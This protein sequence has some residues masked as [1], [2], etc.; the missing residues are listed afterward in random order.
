MRSTITFEIEELGRKKTCL[1]FVV[2]FP[3]FP[4]RSALNRISNNTFQ[5]KMERHMLGSVG[6]QPDEVV[7][8]VE[9]VTFDQ[10]VYK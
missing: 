1:S 7:G 8:T 6:A 5:M 10:R 9:A 3:V 2:V 4:S